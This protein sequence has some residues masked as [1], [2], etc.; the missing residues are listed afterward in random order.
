MSDNK[1]TGRGFAGKG[2]YIALILCAAAIGITGF[3]YYQN[4]NQ[5][6]QISIQET[7][8]VLVGTMGT[9][10][11]AVIA[12][13]PQTKP[14]TAPTEATAPAPTGITDPGTS[15]APQAR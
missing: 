12:T 14:T 7:E 8:D 10:D 1:N 4:A 15:E 3:L 6:E 11:V 9:E 2:Y 5:T 13:Q